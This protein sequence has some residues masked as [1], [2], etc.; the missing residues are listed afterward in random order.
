MEK[1]L[2]LRTPRAPARDNVVGN[3]V[4]C[5]VKEGRAMKAATTAHLTFQGEDNRAKLPPIG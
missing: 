4:I 3:Q 2:D 1:A 5:E